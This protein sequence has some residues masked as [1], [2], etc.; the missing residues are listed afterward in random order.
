M[1]F[2]C[3]II[4]LILNN[5]KERKM[6]SKGGSIELICGCT[7]CGK[8]EEMIRRLRRSVIA[9]Q[10]VKVFRPRIGENYDSGG[11]LSRDGREFEAESARTSQDIKGALLTCNADVVGIDDVHLFDKGIVDLIE[12]LADLGMRVIVSGLDM[13]YECNP[14]E[15]VSLLLSKAEKVDKLPAICKVCGEPATRSKKLEYG[16]YEARCRAHIKV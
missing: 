12:D 16:S 8:T 15:S 2:V 14:Y 9:K 6:E 1:F 5:N 7:S 3:D 11:I 13:D 10:R 4:P